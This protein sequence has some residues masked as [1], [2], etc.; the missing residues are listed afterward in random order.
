MKVFATR[1]GSVLSITFVDDGGGWQ[2]GGWSTVTDRAPAIQP[3][4]VDRLRRFT[5]VG[6]AV[7]YFR[8]RYRDVANA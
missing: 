4:D 1:L 7:D 2:F 8:S 3:D 5:E 6:E